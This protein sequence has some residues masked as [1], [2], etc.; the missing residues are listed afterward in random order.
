MSE[1]PEFRVETRSHFILSFSLLLLLLHRCRF[2]E[3]PTP[4]YNEVT[5]RISK[6][7]WTKARSF[8]ALRGEYLRIYSSNAKFIFAEVNF[9][10]SRVSTLHLADKCVFDYFLLGIETDALLAGLPSD[11]RGCGSTAITWRLRETALREIHTHHHGL[12]HPTRLAAYFQFRRPLDR[13][14]DITL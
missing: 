12:A 1:L 7:E 14:G 11:R 2:V 13:S 4:P 9:I 8:L 3:T 10:I 6:L 5:M